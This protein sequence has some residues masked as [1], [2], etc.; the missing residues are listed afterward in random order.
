MCLL[1]Q[2]FSNRWKGGKS[3]Q[4][5]RE[6]LNRTM[7]TEYGSLRPANHHEGRG[8]AP[9]GLQREGTRRGPVVKQTL[10]A[11]WIG[12]LGLPQGVPLGDSQDPRAAL[13]SA[14]PHSSVPRVLRS[15]V[16]IRLVKLVHRSRR[17]GIR[18]PPRLPLPLRRQSSHP[19]R[20]SPPAPRQGPKEGS[21]CC[22]R[23]WTCG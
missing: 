7:G 12:E 5:P 18:L 23:R 17:P 22:R 2:G 20:Q 9:K 21:S 16:P 19:P 8:C 4:V 14:I 1:W 10:W 3:R 6:S 11:H 15:S 13:L